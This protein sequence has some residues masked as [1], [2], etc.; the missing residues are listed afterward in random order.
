MD[1]IIAIGDLKPGM[2]IVQITQQNGPVK[3][4]KSGLVSS[5]EMVQGLAEMGVLEVEVDPAQAVEIDAPD[6]PQSPTK[7]L[8][9]SANS[10]SKGVDAA[11]SEQFNRSLFLPS[12]QSIPSL[13]QYYSKRSAVG[14]L[15]LAGGIAIG[16]TSATFDHWKESFSK[17]PPIITQQALPQIAQPVVTTPPPAQAVAQQ[18]VV[19]QTQQTI[20]Q[21]ST[22]QNNSGAGQVAQTEPQYQETPIDELEP[23]PADS[24]VIPP[25]GRLV[26]PTPLDEPTGDVSPELL[27]KFNAA[28]DSLRD[29]SDVR[30]SLNEEY[31]EEEIED[32]AP[33][34]IRVDQLPPRLMT[35]LPKMSFAAHMFAS[36]SSDRWVRVNGNELRE[37]DW[38]DQEVQ[39]VEITQNHVVMNFKGQYFRMA[40]L[41]DW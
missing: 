13:W 18:P 20:A 10:S 35:L 36:N 40:A 33:D 30:T 6:V 41:T 15:V 16:W 1:R 22:P 28:V 38:I 14:A 8:L 3:I 24:A 34:V 5:P 9:A 25:Q 19:N 12:V 39:I 4:R 26:S 2:V 32:A 11:L 27:A 21:N 17:P 23:A 29:E 37:G 7:Q 31:P